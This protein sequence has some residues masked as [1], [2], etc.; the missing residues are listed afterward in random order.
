M[1]MNLLNGF[2]YLSRRS[3]IDRIDASGGS[4]LEGAKY[5]KHSYDLER[6]RCGRSDGVQRLRKMSRVPPGDRLQT[7]EFWQG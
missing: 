7:Y 5:A 3:N 4:I 2:E 6:R 1:T